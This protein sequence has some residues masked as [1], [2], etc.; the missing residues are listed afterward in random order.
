L[1]IAELVL[2]GL[3]LAVAAALARGGARTAKNAITDRAANVR[4]RVR[5]VEC[6]IK[7]SILQVS[8]IRIGRL[9]E[10]I[11]RFAGHAPRDRVVVWI[12]AP[13]STIG[14]EITLPAVDFV[15]TA[16]CMAMV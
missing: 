11:L 12:A 1:A 6:S 3:S 7:A 14:M 8:F 9:D 4:G 13:D 5:F 16:R 10:C 2:H 15:D